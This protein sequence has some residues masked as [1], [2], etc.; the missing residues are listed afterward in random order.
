MQAELTV[1]EVIELMNY[2]DQHGFRDRRFAWSNAVSIKY[3]MKRSRNY[4]P[5]AE[6][7]LAEME[8][9]KWPQLETPHADL[10]DEL[11]WKMEQDL[12]R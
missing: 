10:P 12:F 7:F 5:K 8:N 9:I 4:T 11:R 3:L 2:D 1:D 6:T